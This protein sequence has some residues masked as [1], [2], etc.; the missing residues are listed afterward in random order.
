MTRVVKKGFTTGM[1]THLYR[2]APAVAGDRNE[3]DG[4]YV[5]FRLSSAYLKK[6]AFG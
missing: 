1:A 2:K 4:V 6:T 5:G 3:I